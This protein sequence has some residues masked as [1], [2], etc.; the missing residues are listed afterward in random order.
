MAQCTDGGNRVPPED[1]GKAPN[2]HEDTGLS[3][4][5]PKAVAVTYGAF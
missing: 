2:L 3:G 5:S 4:G 1:V